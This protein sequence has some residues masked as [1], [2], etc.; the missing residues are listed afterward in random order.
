[1]LMFPHQLLS[2]NVHLHPEGL[3]QLLSHILTRLFN[4]KKQFYLRF[5]Q[6]R[7]CVQR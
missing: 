2:G 1:M 3:L 7:K 5:F 4:L 6:A